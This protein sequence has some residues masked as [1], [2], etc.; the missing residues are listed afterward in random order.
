MQIP[1]RGEGASTSP[2]QG[3]AQ[4]ERPPFTLSVA[5][6]KSKGRVRGRTDRLGGRRHN[7]QH[8]SSA[9]EGGKGKLRH[10]RSNLSHE[11]GWGMRGEK[12]VSEEGDS[13]REGVMT[14]TM[15]SWGAGLLLALL[16]A[17]PAGGQTAE[18]VEEVFWQSVVCE[19]AVE[20]RLYLEVYPGGTYEAAARACLEAGLGLDRAARRLVQ[21]GLA[22][23]GQEPGP[24]DGL[25]GG[26]GTRTRRAIRGWQAAKG[27]A[28]TGYVTEEQAAALMELG[29]AA[30]A[31][32]Q[33]EQAV[34]EQVAAAQAEQQRAAEARRQA[35]TEKYGRLLQ[36]VRV[37]GGR[38][39]M[40]C[41]REQSGC[42][43]KERPAHQVEVRSFELGKY[44]VTQEL[45]EAVMRT[46][47]SRF[48][49]CAQ[50]P[51]EMV[52]WDDIQAFLRKLNAGGGRYRLPSEAEWEYAARGGRQSRGYRYAGSN[53]P[54]AVAWHDG[55]S[56]WKTHRVGQQQVNELGLHDM[57]GNVWEWVAD[58][59]NANYAGAPSNGRAWTRGDC[60]H[61]VLRG[62]SWILKPWILRSA[63][64]IRSTTGFRYGDFGF[65][66]AR[67]LD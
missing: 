38:F 44:E 31:A 45:W 20:M 36:M 19:D 43:D 60:S 57:S 49:G 52:S 32:Q 24:V 28:A 54:N 11:G 8:P 64:R 35:Q 14:E 18:E 10:Y 5:P 6:A 27:L 46:N 47:P 15:R 3:Y 61:R 22:A 56:G 37:P 63:L 9:G 62:G 25:F 7:G 59:W 33:Q 67:S 66:I 55:N 30:E 29:R 4:H 34:A 48:Q 23:V 21:R 26:P 2:F 65:R 1:G 51:V 58:C 41:T 17:G 13:T 16:W 12:N 40:G 53:N 39:T 50:C 42:T